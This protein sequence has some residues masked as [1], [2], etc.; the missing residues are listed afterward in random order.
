MHAR[1]DV[2]MDGWVGGSSIVTAN[3][4]TLAVRAALGT[5]LPDPWLVI[6]WSTAR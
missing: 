1:V 5:R 2:S 3:V 4:R 6:D